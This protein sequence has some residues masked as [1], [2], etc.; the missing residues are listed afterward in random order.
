MATLRV[1]TKGQVVIPA[2]MRKELGMTPGSYVQATSN[3]KTVELLPLGEDLVEATY[4]MFRGT[5]S[6]QDLLAD[7]AED[8]AIEERKY[9]RWLKRAQGR[10]LQP[11][12]GAVTTSSRPE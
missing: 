5:G 9:Q 3:G 2:K 7:R 6:T 8:V 1:S 11:Q 4:G 12:R 10:K